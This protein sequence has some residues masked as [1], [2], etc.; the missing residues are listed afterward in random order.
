M[1]FPSTEVLNADGRADGETGESLLAQQQ[2]G[3]SERQSNRKEYVS[4]RT[5]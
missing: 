3:F 2:F 4:S 5:K 1:L